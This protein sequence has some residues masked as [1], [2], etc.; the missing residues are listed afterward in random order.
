MRT[1]IVLFLGAFVTCAFEGCASDSSPGD[2]PLGQHDAG[3]CNPAFCQALGSGTACC[4]DNRCGTNLNGMGCTAN[5]RK[6][7]G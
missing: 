2:T 7:G 1:L 4:V 5:P 3:T 6:D